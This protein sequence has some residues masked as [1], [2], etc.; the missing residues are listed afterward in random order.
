M[1]LDLMKT[2]TYL[3]IHLTVGFTVAWV[4]T[5]SLALASG[6][7][8]IEPVINAVA[9]FFHEQAWKKIAARPPKGATRQWFRRQAAF[10]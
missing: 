9:F 2:A 3:T 4:I 10:A 7:A 8:L 6:I 1:S 5:G